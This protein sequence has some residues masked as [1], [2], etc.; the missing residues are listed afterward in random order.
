MEA[1]AKWKSIGHGSDRKA[2]WQLTQKGLTAIGPARKPHTPLPSPLNPGRQNQTNKRTLR[3]QPC[4]QT[5]R[6]R[7]GKQARSQLHSH[8]VTATGWVTAAYSKTKLEESTH[9]KANRL[10]FDSRHLETVGMRSLANELSSRLSGPCE[11]RPPPTS[12]HSSIL[13]TTMKPSALEHS[14]LAYATEAKHPTLLACRGLG[15]A[16]MSN[17]HAPRALSL[18]GSFRKPADAAAE[19]TGNEILSTTITIVVT[20]AGCMLH[21]A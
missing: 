4:R 8:A 10:H 12:T 2:A 14:T 13:I 18:L 5:P 3:A 19:A 6:Y 21:A 16:G 15:T 7:R 17:S 9:L 20:I 11:P 1:C